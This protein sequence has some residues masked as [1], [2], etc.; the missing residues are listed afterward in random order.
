MSIISFDFKNQFSKSCFVDGVIDE[1]GIND[2][3]CSFNLER[4]NEFRS[5]HLGLISE[6]G[7][8]NRFNTVNGLSRLCLSDGE[9]SLFDTFSNRNLSVP[10]DFKYTGF[11]NSFCHSGKNIAREFGSY[12][13]GG[14]SHKFFVNCKREVGDVDIVVSNNFLEFILKFISSLRG[15]VCFVHF[16]GDVF[17]NILH[18]GLSYD[19]HFLPFSYDVFCKSNDF[20]FSSSLGDFRILYPTVA[21]FYQLSIFSN[22][23]SQSQRVLRAGKIM[24]DIN[25]FA[26]L[27]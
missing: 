6:D 11:L 24:S 27:I 4:W 9:G 3:K 2:L 13:T 25:S 8:E 5:S 21:L 7:F 20:R 1:L 22:H 18:N 23:K 19:I 12:I 10:D 15:G 14:L 17:V 26:L 16:E